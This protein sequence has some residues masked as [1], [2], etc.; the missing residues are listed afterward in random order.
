MSDDEI[1]LVCARIEGE[2]YLPDN[3]TGRCAECERMVQ[4]RPHAPRPHRLC[5]LECAI[6]LAR[7]SNSTVEITTTKKMV[8]DARAYFRKKLQ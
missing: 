7:D 4:Y 5:C 6:E 3:L 8:E 1:I 2:P